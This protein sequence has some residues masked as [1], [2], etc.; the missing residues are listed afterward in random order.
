MNESFCSAEVEYPSKLI[1]NPKVLKMLKD[2][3]LKPVHIQIYPT[4]RCNLKCSFCSCADR[5]KQV[6]LYPGK[7]KE[8][9]NTFKDSIQATTI[10]GGGEPLIY[11]ALNELLQFLTSDGKKAGLVTNGLLMNRYTYSDLSPLTWCRISLSNSSGINGVSEIIK[12]YLENLK[13]D[14]AFSFVCSKDLVGDYHVIKQFYNQF[15]KYITHFRIV[16]DILNPS[17]NIYALKDL[18]SD[19]T[20]IIYQER[21]KSG[22]GATKCYLAML[23]PVLTANG[24]IQPCCIHEDDTVLINQDGQIINKKIKNVNIGEYVYNK[25]KI[26]KKWEKQVSEYLLITLKNNMFIRVSKDHLMIKAKNIKIR[27]KVKKIL[28]NYE[29]ENIKADLIKIGDLIPVAYNI[30]N[31]IGMEYFFANEMIEEYEKDDLLWIMGK[32]LSEGWAGT[33]NEKDNSFYFSFGKHELYYTQKLEFLLNKYRIKYKTY[34]RRTTIQFCCYDNKFKSILTTCGERALN[35]KIP[36]F[37]FGMSNEDKECFI[38]SYFEGDGNLTKPSKTY[39]GYTLKFSTISPILC[40]DLILLFKTMGIYACVSKQKRDKMIIEGRTVSCHDIYRITVAGNYNLKKF[41]YFEQDLIRKDINRSP[42]RALGYLK[43]DKEIL[44][45]VKSIEIIK[46]STTMYDIEV[47]GSNEFY[48]SFGILVHNCGSQYAI[49]DGKRDCNA[50]LKMGNIE[51]AKDI[52]SSNYFDT[53]GACQKCFYNN[54]N[55][56]INMFFDDSLIHKEF[57]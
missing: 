31:D 16:D 20:K 54:Y 4:N 44:I 8:F 14:W 47:E 12:P 51:Y 38:I 19:K 24:E 17:G 11:S 41:K 10:S 39:K 43:N 1:A 57:I 55:N 6:E 45:P 49:A 26:L 50:A 37:I 18:L 46:E 48:S 30:D 52:F 56:F 23:K 5:D 21:A 2:R 29:K 22:H 42:R 34:I 32:Y 36:N 40:N 27:Q 7:I 25:G 53:K 3:R 28:K 9:Y 35:K 15:E 13:I 33:K